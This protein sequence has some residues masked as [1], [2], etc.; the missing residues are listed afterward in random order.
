[1]MAGVVLLCGVGP[2][3]ETGDRPTIK[4]IAT[5]P[6]SRSFSIEGSM[7]NMATCRRVTKCRETPS[8]RKKVK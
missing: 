8:L 1:M 3:S 4:C 5:R 7:P 6:V 2:T